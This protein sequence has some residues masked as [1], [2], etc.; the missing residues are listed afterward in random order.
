M[1]RDS[2]LDSLTEDSDLD[3]NERMRAALANI[4]IARVAN[5]SNP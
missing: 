5:M 4:A 2:D 3:K 1:A